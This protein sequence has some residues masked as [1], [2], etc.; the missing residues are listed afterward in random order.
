MTDQPQPPNANPP[1]QPTPDPKPD[2]DPDTQAVLD[3]LDDDIEEQT[4]DEG[5]KQLLQ[6]LDAIKP[7]TLRPAAESL[8]TS[9]AEPTDAPTTMPDTPPTELSESESPVPPII[10]YRYRVTVT[11]PNEIR[12]LMDAAVAEVGLDTSLVQANMVW[13]AEFQTQTEETVIETIE[14]WYNDNLPL[15]TSL[16]RVYA[17][18]FG[19]QDYVA[20]WRLAEEDNLQAAHHRLTMQLAPLITVEPT[21][22]T[23]FHTFLP[24]S[25][26]V[27]AP[28]FPKL[29]AYLQR[30]FDDVAWQ[31][32]SC[33]LRRQALGEDG[34]PSAD[35]TWEVSRVFKAES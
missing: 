1:V 5:T 15:Q 32:S 25:H 20:G 35:A 10:H 9:A 27:P 29:V 34:K 26:R 16:R 33:E 11:P 8:I 17:D 12:A 24:I 6:S 18:V 30:H 4:R 2:L 28:Q 31:I 13:Q 14:R 7:Q 23:V 19:A 21:A 22:N 3:A